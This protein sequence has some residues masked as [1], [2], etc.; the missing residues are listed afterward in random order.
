MARTLE[1]SKGRS[2]RA[3]S[4]S[5]LI[6]AYFQ[7]SEYAELSARAVKALI[8]LYCQY[9]G[10]NNGDFCAARKFMLPL[11]WKSQSQLAKALNELLEKGWI[12]ITRQG[13]RRVAT[14]YAAS[15]LGIDAC[16][17]KLD[18]AACSTPSHLW[19]RENRQPGA[20]IQRSGR[21]VIKKG[22]NLDTVQCA[23]CRGSIERAANVH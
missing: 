21:R 10:N 9:R 3:R 22:V 7:S 12:T 4:F 11:G 1:K 8:D 23:P 18:V 14:L 17:G 2:S 5:M 13:G 19:K 16:G 15:F 20:E 6:H